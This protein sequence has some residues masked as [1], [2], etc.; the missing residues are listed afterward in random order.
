MN[1]SKLLNKWR[2]KIYKEVEERSGLAFTFSGRMKLRF[3]KF[4]IF[5]F[6]NFYNK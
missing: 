5:L 1:K 4:I 3:Q 6:P 2:K